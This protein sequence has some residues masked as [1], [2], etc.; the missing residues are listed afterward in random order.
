M[1]D[2]ATSFPGPIVVVSG[3]PCSESLNNYNMILK[4]LENT[5]SKRL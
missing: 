3:E 5:M 4:E 2:I 1:S